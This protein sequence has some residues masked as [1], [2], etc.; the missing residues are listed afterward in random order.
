MIQW[1]HAQQ[2]WS[3]SWAWAFWAWAGY[4]LIRTAYSYIHHRGWM[5]GFEQA[6]NLSKEADERFL[7]SLP[8]I[9]A[10]ERAK[11]R[12]GLPRGGDKTPPS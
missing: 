11:I 7:K 8:F 4:S 6:V 2:Q 9:T 3:Y 10:E 1:L 5:Q 12:W